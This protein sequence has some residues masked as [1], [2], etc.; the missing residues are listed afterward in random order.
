MS[1]RT[2]EYRDRWEQLK[3]ERVRVVEAKW[4]DI[5]DYFCPERGKFY[6]DESSPDSSQTLRG[7]KI[8]DSTGQ[9]AMETATNGM[10][11]GLTPPSRPW[12]RLLFKDDALNENAGA[13]AWLERLQEIM[14]SSCQASNF[15]PS[16]Q[17]LDAEVLAFATGCLYQEPDPKHTVRYRIFTAGEYWLSQNQYGRVDTVYRRIM[18]TARQMVQRFSESR[19]S[20]QAQESAKK[21]PTKSYECV[22]CVQPRGSYDITKMDRMNQPYESIYFEVGNDFAIL[23]EG[24]FKKFPYLTPRYVTIGNDCYGCASPGWKKLP[25]I[26][27]LQDMEESRIRTVHKILDPPMMAPSSLK[28]QPLRSGSGGITYYDSSQPDGLKPLYQ[29]QGRVN[30]LTEEMQELRQRILKGWYVDIFLM[31][32]QIRGGSVTATEVLEKVE[33]KKLQL[34]PFIERHQGEVLQP[35]LDFL[36]EQIIVTGQIEAPPDEIVGADYDIEFISPLAQAQKVSGAKAIDDMLAFVGNAAAI[37]PDIIDNL[38]FDQAFKER[39]SLVG[40]PLKIMRP[41]DAVLQIRQVKAQQMAEAHA[42]QQAAAMVQ[43]ANQL[44]NTPTDPSAPNALTDIA[45]MLQQQSGGV[46]A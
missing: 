14:Y 30:E 36:I 6:T 37:N 22:H 4:K 34:G 11:S 32:E 35:A 16:M 9:D 46:P 25:D 31:I 2:N 18:M 39:S 38:D 43:G 45:K 40:L 24:G 19:V 20:R 8:L 44:G 15:Y 21:E 5:A 33:E 7:S 1:E 23:Q 26:K 41:M 3:T 29:V 13:K 42:Q 10:F 27:M 12:F 28:G 17:S